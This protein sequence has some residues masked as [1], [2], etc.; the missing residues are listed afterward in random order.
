M[1]VLAVQYFLNGI[2]PDKCRKGIIENRYPHNTR[3]VIDWVLIRSS[4][5]IHIYLMKI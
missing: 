1:N 3:D 5:D 2:H 4:P